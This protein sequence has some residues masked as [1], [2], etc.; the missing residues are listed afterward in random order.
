MSRPEHSEHAAGQSDVAPD[1]LR[2]SGQLNRHR[3][4]APLADGNVAAH[5]EFDCPAVD[6][7]HN[8]PPGRRDL[9]E[10]YRVI[11]PELVAREVELDLGR[12]VGRGVDDEVG[13]SRANRT[14]RER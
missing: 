5:I 11:E 13:L 3:L 10:P 9:P 2:C 4:R 1:L 8:E 7:L 6:R 12:R 14:V